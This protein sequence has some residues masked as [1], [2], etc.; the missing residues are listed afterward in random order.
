VRV[1]QALA[2]AIDRET[3]RDTILMGIP[4]VA[5]GPI[6]SLVYGFTPGLPPR[7]YDPEGARALLEE[8]GAVGAEVEVGVLVGS[9]PKAED[10]G[11]ALAK[12]FED[13][14]LKSSFYAY[15]HGVGT[16]L[17]K[18]GV[19]D[20]WYSGCVNIAGEE[21]FCGFLYSA[22]FNQKNNEYDNPHV[23]ELYRK[24]KEEPDADKRQEMYDEMNAIVWEEVA[25][26]NMFDTVMMVATHESVKDFQPMP[27]LMHRV[28]INTHIA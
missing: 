8:A 6:G 10:I 5:T 17:L 18:E 12:Y 28:T 3:I 24:I 4:N 14:G 25:M 23:T 1:R 19:H 13:I 7:T 11:E 22:D 15:E 27:N 21:Y 9:F 16:K 26:L 2:K 20:V